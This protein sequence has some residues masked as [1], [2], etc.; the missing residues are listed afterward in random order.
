V[1]YDQMARLDRTS[2]YQSTDPPPPPVPW[3]VRA[4]VG[5][6][7]G[8]FI[9]TLLATFS[10]DSRDALGSWWAA[11]MAFAILA[12]AAVAAS[13]WLGRTVLGKLGSGSAPRALVF[14]GLFGS[15]LGIV[16]LLGV[17]LPVA[18]LG[19]LL[20]S[21]PFVLAVSL[22]WHNAGKVSTGGIV[23]AGVVL[24]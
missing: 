22:F 13:E 14:L 23:T 24:F 19:L 12:W 16:A 1:V 7:A 9:A 4:V 2:Q 3:K 15:A 18:P 8:I 10:T 5:F 20:T 17:V 11:A 21:L 6:A